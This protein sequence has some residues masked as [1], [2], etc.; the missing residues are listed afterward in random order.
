VSDQNPFYGDPGPSD[1]DPDVGTAEIGLSSDAPAEESP[2]AYLDLD[3]DTANRYVRVRVDGQE[4]EVP[5]KE[6][7]AGYSRTA[8]YTRKTQDLASQRQQAEYALAVERALKAQPEETLRLLA[9][10]YGVNFEQSPPQQLREQPSTYDDGSDRYVDPVERRLAEMERQ[11]Q[12]LQQ[13]WQQR[14][15]DEQLRQAVAGITQRYQLSDADTREVVSTALQN[16]MGPESFDMIWKNIAFDRAQQARQ[17]AQQ[18][19]AARQQAAANASQLVGNGS[20]ATRAGT[21]P[22][23]ESSGPMTI[24]Q[25]FDLALKEHRIE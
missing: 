7:L 16:R 10:Q 8:D 13:Q 2:K 5:L 4:Q 14:Q 17:T 12:A 19:A 23:P 24:A 1:G 22:A 20:S 11:N 15:A 3:D 21:S 25:A 6:A 18:Q 9:R